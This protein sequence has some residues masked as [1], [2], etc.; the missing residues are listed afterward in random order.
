MVPYGR[1]SPDVLPNEPAPLVAVRMATSPALA[2][3]MVRWWD[4]GW[5]VLPLD[6][7]LPGA[8]AERLLEELRPERLV[9]P[10]ADRALPSPLPASPGVAVVLPTSGTTGLPK[11]VEL[12]RSN[13]EAAARAS[14][15]RLGA[16]PG[17]RWLCCLPLHHIAG[18]GVLNRSLLAGVEPVVHAGFDLSAVGREASV[19]LVSLVPTML[20]RLLDAGVDLSRFRR[21][22]LGGAAGPPALL[23]RAAAAGARVVV[24][25]GSTETCGGVVY[26]GVPLDGVKV[27]TAVMDEEAGRPDSGS[28]A[29]GDADHETCADRAPDAGHAAPMGLISISGPT[30][31]AGYKGR[32]DLTASVLSGGWFRTSDLGR[33][34]ERGRLEVVGRADGVIVTGGRK[35]APEEVEAV[36]SDHPLIAEVAVAGVPDPEWGECVTAFVVPTASAP[37]GSPTLEALRGLAKERLPA[38]KAPR[39]RVLLDSLPRTPSGKPLRRVLANGGHAQDLV[40]ERGQRGP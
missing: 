19:T 17:D 37:P 22:L 10:G 34:D 26:D 3:E 4:E 12:T 2:A 29:I 9:E 36:L 32:P 5:A 28:G 33:F 15:A 30:V 35:V 13:L 25:Y 18:I 40:R 14:R 16:E 1:G 24:T 20:V 23:R 31:M 38:Y 27:A 6:P 39:A 7:A 11:G 8:G 21:I